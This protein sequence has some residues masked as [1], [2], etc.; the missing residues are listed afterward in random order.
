MAKRNFAALIVAGL[1]VLT[2]SNNTRAEQI[3]AGLDGCSVLAGLV[4]SEVTA[5]AWSS[6][7][8]ETPILG[9]AIRADI[10]ICNRTAQTVSKAFTL[11]MMSVGSDVRWDYPSGDRG[12]YCWSGFLDQCYPQR[13]MFGTTTQSW[14]VV[15]DTV[16]RAM[17]RGSAT[18][19]SVFSQRAMRLALRSALLRDMLSDRPG[20]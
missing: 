17:P 19:Q 20:H 10:S 14:S 7:G 9:D 8:V 13:S 5:S 3:F 2:F 12:D 1:A 4:Y 16:R 18:D 6:P 11:A 15:S